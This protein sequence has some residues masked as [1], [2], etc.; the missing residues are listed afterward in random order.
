L[1]L[2][3]DFDNRH[4]IFLERIA[5]LIGF[6]FGFLLGILLYLEF[7]YRIDLC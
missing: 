3:S 6:A 2:L 5:N 1:D 4:A 7:D